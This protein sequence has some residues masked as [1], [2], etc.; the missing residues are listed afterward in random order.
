MKRHGNLYFKICS[1]E[2]IR[3]AHIN[4]QKNKKHY[5]SVKEINK[6]PKKY[7]Q[8]IKKTVRK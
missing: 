2:N 5:S 7:L 8:E 3:T 4:A 1:S 6:N